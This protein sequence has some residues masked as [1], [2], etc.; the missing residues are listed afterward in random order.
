MSLKE[1]SQSVVALKNKYRDLQEKRYSTL[2]P[3]L[4]DENKR[5]IIVVQNKLYD[6]VHDLQVALEAETGVNAFNFPDLL[7][8]YGFVTGKDIALPKCLEVSLDK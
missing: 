8:D 4:G 3:T 7:K 5:E 2:S 6:A 1:L